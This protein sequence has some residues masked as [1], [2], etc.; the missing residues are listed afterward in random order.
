[1]LL[2]SIKVKNFRQFKGEQYVSFSTDSERNVT[3]V[4]GDN[5]SGKTSFAQAFR[6]CLYGITDFSD[7]MLF[8]KAISDQMLPGDEHDMQVDICLVHNDIE[9]AVTR[10]Q[11]FKKDSSNK[12]TYQGRNKF[13][14]SYK[15]SD[16]NIAYIPELET[17]L[18]MREILPQDL[19]RYFFFD[20]EHI[21]HM[22]KE[23]REGRSSD[24]A[25]AVRSLLGLKAFTSSLKHLKEIG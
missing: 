10:R 3:I 15:G 20:G 5:G 7:K 6:W 25:E 18:K 2:K 1:M 16:G 21:E 8:S 23:I 19:S 24:F 9:Y 17:E 4:Q 12:I 14:I 13:A 22:A 11:I